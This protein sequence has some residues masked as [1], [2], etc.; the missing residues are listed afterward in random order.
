[1]KYVYLKKMLA[2]DVVMPKPASTVGAADGIERN[3]VGIE[4]DSIDPNS[5]DSE[6]HTVEAYVEGK[7]GGQLIKICGCYWD[8]IPDPDNKK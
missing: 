4:A 5:K 6:C 1:M 8:P 3:I 7:L 2:L